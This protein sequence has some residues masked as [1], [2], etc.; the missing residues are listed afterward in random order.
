MEPTVFV[1]C[2]LILPFI[3]FRIAYADISSAF[4]KCSILLSLSSTSYTLFFTYIITT[5][6]IIYRLPVISIL[7][8]RTEMNFI[9]PAGAVPS[10]CSCGFFLTSPC[11][12][13]RSIKDVFGSEGVRQLVFPVC[14]FK[15]WL[16]AAHVLTKDL[17]WLK[18]QTE[19]VNLSMR[20]WRVKIKYHYL[21]TPT[22]L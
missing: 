11:R 17:C 1:S 22:Q 16:M 13:F 12:E 8:A 5:W 14:H 4:T 7:C 19:T 6:Q 9:H 2:I 10:S 20:P 15:Q 18:P 21:M 3:S